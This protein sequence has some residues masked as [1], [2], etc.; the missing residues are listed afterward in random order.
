[1]TKCW[2][3]TAA[4]AAKLGTVVSGNDSLGGC[5]S[6]RRR[7]RSPERKCLFSPPQQT[8]KSLSE[9]RWSSLKLPWGF[10]KH[11]L[12][13]KTPPKALR[14]WASVWGKPPGGLLSRASPGGRSTFKGF[15]ASLTST[16]ESV[17]IPEWN[18]RDGGRGEGKG[19]RETQRK[20]GREG[21]RDRVRKKRGN[22]GRKALGNVRK[23]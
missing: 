9:P 18:S 14:R 15:D 10:L 13:P 3:I 1:M 6:W 4:V 17:D 5:P 21:G 12:V 16:P 23:G 19:R 2:Q 11:P 7:S 20:E 22:K 8:Y